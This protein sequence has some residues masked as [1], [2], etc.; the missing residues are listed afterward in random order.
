M[1]LLLLFDDDDDDDDDVAVITSC[2]AC[3]RVLLLSFFDARARQFVSTRTAAHH[4][5]T[6]HTYEK[7]EKLNNK[8]TTENRIR[9]NFTQTV[10]TLT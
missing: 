3:L 2:P 5:W 1:L 10:L 4:Q 7:T 8:Q 6:R 9:R